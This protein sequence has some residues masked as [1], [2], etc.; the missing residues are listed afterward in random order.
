MPR[1]PGVQILAVEQLHGEKGQALGAAGR[2]LTD[3]IDHGDVVVLERR[4]RPRLAE[5]ALPQ[6]RVVGRTLA[7][8]LDRDRPLEVGVFRPVDD[9]HAAAADRPHDAVMGELPEVFRVRFRVGGVGGKA[10][11]VGASGG[12]GGPRRPRS[13]RASTAYAAAPDGARPVGE[14]RAAARATPVASGRIPHAA[15]RGWPGRR[16]SRDVPLEFVDELR[17]QLPK[18]ELFDLA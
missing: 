8:H 10:F 4:H 1:H 18:G 15:V 14:C 5:K 13:R 16:H 6:L 2:R 17:S 12:S 9:P 3:L 7:E 11:G